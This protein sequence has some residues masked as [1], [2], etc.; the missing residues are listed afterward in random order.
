MLTTADPDTAL[1]QEVEGCGRLVP[2]GDAAALARELETLLDDAPE[3]ARLGAAARTRAV[4]RWDMT[5]ILARF[6]GQLRALIR[7]PRPAAEE[8]RDLRT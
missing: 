6:Q 4:E 8:Q 5:S 3:R 7:D 1:G 2:P